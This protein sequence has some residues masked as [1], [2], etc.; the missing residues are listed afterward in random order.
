M[1]I[2][3]AERSQDTL[4]EFEPTA[5]ILGRSLLLHFNATNPNHLVRFTLHRLTYLKN[6]WLNEWWVRPY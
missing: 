3:P 4:H 6:H 1:T 5:S 2:V